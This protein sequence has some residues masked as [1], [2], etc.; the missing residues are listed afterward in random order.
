[1]RH[2]G[3]ALLAAL[4]AG[5]SWLPPPAGIQ[6]TITARQDVRALPVIVVDNAEIVREAT[7]AEIPAGFSGRTTVDPD[8]DHGL[9]RCRHLPRGPAVAR[10]ASRAPRLHA[11]R[12]LLVACASAYS[13]AIQVRL[14]ALLTR[15]SLEGGAPWRC[16]SF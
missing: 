3:V 13:P 2:L 6:L 4:L 7:P 10:P 8:R 16:S 15:R 14:A 12:G 9:L 1:M 11:E 5:S